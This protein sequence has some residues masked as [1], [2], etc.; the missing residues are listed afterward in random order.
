[1]PQ[2]GSL[3]VNY[4][5]LSSHLQFDVSDL[6]IVSGYHLLLILILRV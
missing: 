6:A 1:M 3:L 2:L 4:D 5:K